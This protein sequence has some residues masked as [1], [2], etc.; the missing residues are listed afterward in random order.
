MTIQIYQHFTMI[1]RSIKCSIDGLASNTHVSV[2][3]SHVDQF[4][5][6]WSNNF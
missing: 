5:Y 2:F 6:L 3:D 1:G 4:H